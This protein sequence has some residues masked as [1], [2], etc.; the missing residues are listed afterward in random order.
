MIIPTIDKN[1]TAVSKYL[2]DN[3]IKHYSFDF[4][5]TIAYSNPT[6]KQKRAEFIQD[7]KRDINSIENIKEAFSKIGSEYNRTQESGLKLSSPLVL[8]KKVLIELNIPISSDTLSFIKFEIDNL[9]LK[10]PPVLYTNLLF[11]L[12][13]IVK[14]GKTI[15]ITSNTAFI[16]GYI[17]ER[18]LKNISL[19]DKF[20]FLLFSDILGFAK[21]NNKIF[22]QLYIHAKV[23][24]PN[25]KKSEV[26]HF[27]DNSNTDYFGALNYGFYAFKF[28]S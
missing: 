21:P 3:E 24:H 22:E 9:F 25:L 14:S 18:F 19:I 10:Y 11:E 17:I 8:L 15:S 16:S 2:N 1:W 7:L 4:W 23:I 27:G 13:N 5:E 20:S 26:I 6:F 12:E 28:S